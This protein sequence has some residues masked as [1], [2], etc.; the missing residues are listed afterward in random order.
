MRAYRRIRARWTLAPAHVEHAAV[1]R[2][3]SLYVIAHEVPC[4]MLLFLFL[5]PHHLRKIRVSGERKRKLARRK[6]VQLFYPD[7]RSLRV[8]R[9]IARR[10]QVVEELAA[11]QYDARYVCGQRSTTVLQHRSKRTVD[12][13]AERRMRTLIGMEL[14]LR[15]HHDKRLR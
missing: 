6:R 2:N 4:A 3:R 14:P 12:Q 7:E 13:F 8:A 9:S 1:R 11:A 5:G 15:R 10:L